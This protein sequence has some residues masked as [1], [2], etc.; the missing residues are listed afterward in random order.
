MLKYGNRTHGNFLHVK[1]RN[2]PNFIFC[3]KNYHFWQNSPSGKLQLINAIFST[4]KI[5]KNELFSKNFKNW[6]F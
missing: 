5:N 2:F 1:R 4:I 6:P 3:G